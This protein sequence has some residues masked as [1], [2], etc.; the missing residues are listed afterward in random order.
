MS[1]A[2]GSIDG[3][4]LVRCLLDTFGHSEDVLPSTLFRTVFNPDADPRCRARL[5]AIMELRR[6]AQGAPDPVTASTQA[7]VRNAA[8]RRSR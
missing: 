2:L 3:L 1:V 7:Q 4:T 6:A 8:A 5:S